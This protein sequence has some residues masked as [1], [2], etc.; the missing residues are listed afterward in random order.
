MDEETEPSLSAPLRFYKR[1][2]RM[3]LN[4]TLEDGIIR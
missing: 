2:A 1:I 3:D 4:F